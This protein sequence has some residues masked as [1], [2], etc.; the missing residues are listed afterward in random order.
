MESLVHIGFFTSVDSIESDAELGALAIYC[1]D[2]DWPPMSIGYVD[3]AY[4]RKPHRYATIRDVV[5]TV[6][7]FDHLHDRTRH[8]RKPVYRICDTL[9]YAG[10]I[11]Y[12]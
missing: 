4:H 7:Q 10:E 3:G 6:E 9:F 1:R 5:C 12:L 11:T 2:H 8:F